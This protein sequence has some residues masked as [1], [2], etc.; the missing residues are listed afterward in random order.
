MTVSEY[1]SHVSK[2]E[3]FGALLAAYLLYGICL[4][5]Y[6]LYLSPI[7]KF[8]GPK[9]AAYTLWYEFYYDVVKRGRFA[10]EIKR[11]HEVYGACPPPPVSP[12]ST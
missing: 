9:L 12:F 4:A 8:P 5:I 3:A 6:R 11:M 10:W 1:L 2:L 7:S